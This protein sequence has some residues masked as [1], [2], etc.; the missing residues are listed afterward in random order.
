MLEFM[1]QVYRTAMPIYRFNKSNVLNSIHKKNLSPH[2][3]VNGVFCK[4]SNLGH[5]LTNIK[6]ARLI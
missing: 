3:T 6:Q 1:H 4:A 2:L 5:N